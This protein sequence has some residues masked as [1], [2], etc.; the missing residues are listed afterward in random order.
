[1]EEKGILGCTTT[2]DPCVGSIL[3]EEA[4][5][6]F[7]G[8]RKPQVYNHMGPMCGIHLGGG[9]QKVWRRR[10][11][12]KSLFHL[13]LTSLHLLQWPNIRSA[14]SAVTVT[15]LQR[16]Q[17]GAVYDNIVGAA[18]RPK[19]R[20]SFSNNADLIIWQEQPQGACRVCNDSSFQPSVARVFASFHAQ[21]A[22]QH[23]GRRVPRDPPL[24]TG[25]VHLQALLPQ[26]LQNI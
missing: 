25:E 4:T 14:T 5:K 15:L 22:A 9:I 26:V 6:N 13:H 23:Q 3:E 11:N 19:Q 2:L 8:R 1:L 16:Q 7:G 10:Q 21:G 17:Q 12:Q 20:P 18:S 24:E